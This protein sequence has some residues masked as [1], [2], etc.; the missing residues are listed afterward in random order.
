MTIV[1]WV[2]P[3]ADMPRPGANPMKAKRKRAKPGEEEQ[4]RIKSQNISIVDS[5]RH[6]DRT[7]ITIVCFLKCIIHFFLGALM[8][9]FIQFLMSR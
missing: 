7:D 6:S 9:S 1:F 4:A 2:K 3:T 5:A 8:D